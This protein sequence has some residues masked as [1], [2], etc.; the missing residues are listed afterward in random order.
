MN[1]LN[2]S[3][4]TKLRTCSCLKGLDGGARWFKARLKCGLVGRAR[5]FRTRLGCGL[6]TSYAIYTTFIPNH[7][8]ETWGSIGSNFATRAIGITI[9]IEGLTRIIRNWVGAARK[10]RRGW[11]GWLGAIIIISTRQG[12]CISGLV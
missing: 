11:L 6:I 3:F 1:F 10:L 2:F 4:S 12:C 5:W 8:D 7:S 9:R